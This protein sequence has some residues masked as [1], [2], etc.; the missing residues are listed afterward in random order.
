[1]FGAFK[2]NT[3]RVN[4]SNRIRKENVAGV[5]EKV[6]SRLRIKPMDIIKLE[7]FQGEYS[8]KTFPEFQ[9]ISGAEADKI[10]KKIA[11]LI[12][13]NPNASPLELVRFLRQK[14]AI[15]PSK[16][17]ML[18]DF[19][20]ESEIMQLGVNPHDEVYINWYRFDNID[21]IK[22]VDLSTYFDDIWFARADDIDVF[23]DSFS[24]IFSIGYLGDLSYLKL[25]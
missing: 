9:T 16:N 12:G 6:T 13:F 19:N 4:R 25:V 8:D 22:L 20:L 23:D 7:N 2:P 17:A 5:E 11:V 14:A 24:W 18:N 10:R 15:I 3:D 1:M 21:R